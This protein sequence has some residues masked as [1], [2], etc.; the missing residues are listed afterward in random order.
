MST[1][2]YHPIFTP[3]ACAAIIGFASGATTSAKFSGLQFTAE[4]LHR[5]PKTKADW[6]FFQKTKNY[7][8]ILGGIFGGFKVGAKLGFWTS[9][10]CCLKEAFTH[11]GISLIE[12]N[13]FL[14]GG[15]SGLTV[16][17]SSSYFYKLQPIFLPSRLFIG[18]F[19]GLL[20]GAGEDARTFLSID[21]YQ[22]LKYD[23]DT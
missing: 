10:F 16:A 2:A 4:N 13:K 19:L 6:Y 15:L 21:K 8:V 14:A 3:T 11:S 1:N 18:S 7:K 17:I 12:K 22:D 23:V 9:G 5:L 20:A